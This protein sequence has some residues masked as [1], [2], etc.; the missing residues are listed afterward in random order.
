MASVRRVLLALTFVTLL[1][2]TRASFAQEQAP[3]ET[4]ASHESEPGEHGEH[5]ATLDPK[6]LG[7]QL[8]NFGLLCLILGFFGGRAINK[9]L[10]ARH[11][12]MK[13]D[14]VEAAEARAAAEGRLKE[15]ERRLGNLEG[16]VA[17]L[18]AAIKDEAAREEKVLIAAAEEKAQRLKD[19]TRFLMDQQ[20]RQAENSFRE[21][22]ANAAVRI[23]E[24]VLRRSVQPDDDR[25]L[26]QSFVTDLEGAPAPHAPSVVPTASKE[27]RV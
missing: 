19:E 2:S 15:Q 12:Q 4:A 27:P 18:R 21:E 6:R 7:F 17:S 26:D 20:V 11:E 23:A 9:A 3:P 5:H 8:I 24:E 25:R 16:E 14:L 22:V 10:L 1:V 13:K